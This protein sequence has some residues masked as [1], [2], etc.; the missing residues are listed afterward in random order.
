MDADYSGD[1]RWIVYTTRSSSAAY[2]CSI[3]G[4][5]N[6]QRPLDFGSHRAAGLFSVAFSPDSAEVLVGSSD[7]CMYT[8]DLNRDV[9]TSLLAGHS[10]DVNTAVF[11]E[12]VGRVHGSCGHDC[13]LPA[14]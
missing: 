7:S 11:P 12:K 8:Y 9:R 10:D 1:R 14:R 5:W 4:D 2:L 13:T 6:V 3:H